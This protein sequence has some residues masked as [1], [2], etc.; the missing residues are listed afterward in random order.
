MTP[1]EP[2]KPSKPKAGKQRSRAAKAAKQ[3]SDK[4]GASP[5]RPK[6]QVSRKR[7]APTPK[8]NAI[9]AEETRNALTPYEAEQ[10]A[11]IKAWKEKEPSVVD[12]AMGLVVQ[13][14]AWMIRKVVPEKA[15]AG[16]LVLAR[17]VSTKTIDAG[18]VLRKAGVNSIADVRNTDL[19]RS[20][21]LANE[22]HNWAI[23]LATAEGA[24]TG[25]FGILGA[26]VDIPAL[27]TLALRTVEKIGLCYGYE[28]NTRQDEDFIMGV[29]AVAGANTIEEKLSALAALRTIQTM[30][31][32]QTWRKIAEAAAK[33]QLSKEGAI[34]GIRSLAKQLS[35]NITKR[36]AL[37]AIPFIGSLVGG[38][39]NAWYLRD[40]GW[41][42]RRLFQ[43]RRLT[44]SG[45]LP[46]ATSP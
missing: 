22:V 42:A 34:I 3:P 46:S 5:K 27:I 16:A 36:K 28:C 23:G 33:T 14:F 13:P 10:A 4:K 30:L 21:R 8:E 17:K 29:L 11:E 39:L 44:E 20:D 41:S 1:E 37:A 45:K 19:E 35:I 31:V 7:T 12:Q 43:E 9:P 6:T 26:P 25:F 24:G 40:V 32:K 38:S 2:K 18:D 15:I